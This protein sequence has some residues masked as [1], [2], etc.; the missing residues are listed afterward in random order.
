MKQPMKD[1]M[2]KDLYDN[3]YTPD[4]AIYPLIYHLPKGAMTIWE[5]TDFGKSNI[6]KILR[7][8]H[9]NVI[10]SDIVNGFDFLKDKMEQPFDMIVTNPPYSLKD[11]FIEK[12]Y[13]YGKPF[14]L[15]LP[16][17]ALEG[18]KRGN[19]FREKGISVIV[20]DKRIDFTGKKACWF[21]V[22]WFCWKI[23]ADNDIIFQNVEKEI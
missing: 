2:S 23:L 4:Q 13:E 5:C 20:L 22:S 6:T 12:C 10:G 3:L 9:Y 11:K 15:L 8:K 14:A 7:D 19:L 17:T 18:I 1:M 16:L 21:N